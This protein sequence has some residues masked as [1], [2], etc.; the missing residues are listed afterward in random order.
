M[1]GNE[2]GEADEKPER[3]V[4][5]SA[6]YID[7]YEVTNAE[8]KHFVD[9]TNR[10][11]PKHWKGQKYPKGMGKFPVVNVSWKDASDYAEWVGK[12]LPTEAE[13]ERAALGDFSGIKTR[14]RWAWG[15]RW[16]GVITSLVNIQTGRGLAPIDRHPDG[17]TQNNIYNMCGNAWEWVA[18][19]YDATYYSKSGI[20][21]NPTGPFD[22]TGLKAVRGGISL[23]EDG[24][25][26]SL[27][28]REKA[29]P[30]S[31]HPGIGFRCVRPIEN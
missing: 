25:M 23:H 2:Y 9:A 17:K 29:S 30:E 8:Y 28:N 3:L 7:Q 12:R 14:P 4:N 31:G 11:P 1:M 27:T 16:N 6:Y 24:F 21:S 20:S 22:N 5:L 26:T 10:M 19:W 18:D 13:W 15:N